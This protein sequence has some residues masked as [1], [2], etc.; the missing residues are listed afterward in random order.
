MAF[1]TVA[2]IGAGAWGTALAQAAA[3]AGRTVTLVCRDAGRAAEIN[4]SHSNSLYLRDLELSTN[5]QAAVTF[6]GGTDFVI[7]AVPA[8]SSRAVL[9]RFGAEAF[10]GKPVI[11]SAKGLET[12][13]L[14]RQSEILAEVAPGAAP[15]VLSG[16]SF[17]ADV[18]A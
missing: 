4:E 12:G 8:Q 15:Y 14:L 9:N 3:I 17:A 18:A 1:D 11:L 2:V 16:P 7:L 6:A 5:I 13:T 10:A